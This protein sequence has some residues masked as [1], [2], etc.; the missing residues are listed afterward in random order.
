MKLPV[1]NDSPDYQFMELLISAVQKLVIKDVVIYADRKIEKTKE[2]V[3]K[4]KKF[5]IWYGGT[6]DEKVFQRGR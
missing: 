2:V 3:K 1:I 6:K 4:W 5:H